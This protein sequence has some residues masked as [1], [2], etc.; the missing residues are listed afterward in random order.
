VTKISA[1]LRN[2][3][4]TFRNFLNFQELGTVMKEL[5]KD[6]TE[7]ELRGKIELVRK[8]GTKFISFLKFESLRL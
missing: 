6:P 7:E 5:G 2:D 4:L 8:L 3:F 1:N